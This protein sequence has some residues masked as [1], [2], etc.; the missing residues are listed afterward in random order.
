MDEAVQFLTHHGEA[1]LFWV[2]LVD[3]AGLPIPAVPLLIAAGVLVGLGKMHILAALGIPVL[4]SVLPD[5][6]WYYLG[7]SQGGKVLG[8]LCRISLEPDSCVRR[9]ENLFLQ[10]GVRSLV[11]AKFVPG[12][13]TV[14]PPLAGI[15]GMSVRRFLLYD[16]LGA[17]AWT[18]VF[19]SL[20]LVFMD[21]LEQVASVLSQTGSF[22]FVIIAASVLLYVAVKYIQR[23]RFLRQLRMDR[24]TV[25]ELKQKM[26]A[27]EE[28]AIVDVRH[29]VD[30][31]ASPHVIPGALHIGLEE[32]DHRHHEIPR[33]RDIVLYCACPNEVS[34]A[35]TALR[36]K[37]KGVT[38]VRPLIG[39]IDEWRQRNFPLEMVGKRKDPSPVL[40]A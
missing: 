31:E 35:R 30:F 4:A 18:V 5:L 34:S 17:L 1:L 22:F 37:R 19:T 14:A 15:F 39:G 29:M 33:D 24:I 40:P 11:V 36:L 21:Q 3:Q 13:G 12:L 25:D 9:T 23:Q 10:H 27:G 38:R 20:G 6:I 32:I 8:W 28:V 26:D 7:R 16:A 2:V